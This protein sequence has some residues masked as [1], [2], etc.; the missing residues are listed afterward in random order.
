M[1]CYINIKTYKCNIN[2]RNFILTNNNNKNIAS[3][4][5]DKNLK[6]LEHNN[7]LIV[8]KNLAQRNILGQNIINCRSFN[9]DSA[10]Q[11]DFIGSFKSLNSIP[12]FSFP[13]IGFIGRSNVGKSS[14]LNC[15]TG[16]NKKIAVEGKTPGRTQSINIFSC[17]DKV[18]DICFLVDLPGYI[19]I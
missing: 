16:L 19:L 8:P 2:N 9:L 11:F 6:V 1:Y 17:K 3:N 18:G 5:F 15:L 4:I 14:L 7:K 10:K 13:E 12:I